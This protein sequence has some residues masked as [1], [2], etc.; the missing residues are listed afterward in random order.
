MILLYKYDLLKPEEVKAIPK[1]TRQDWDK[2]NLEKCYGQDICALY[3]S[4]LHDLSGAFKYSYIR[5]I[6]STSV[7]IQKTLTSLLGKSK[8]FKKVKRD[9]SAE[10]INLIHSLI[11][12]GISIK[13]ACKFLDV[14]KSWYHYHRNK[15]ECPK[16]LFK[17]CF[18]KHPNQLT[19]KEQNKIKSWIFLDKNQ[20]K[21][22]T[23]IFPYSNSMIEGTFHLFKHDFLRG[24]T[25]HSLDEVK[26]KTKLFEEHVA[27]RYFTEL[28]GL[29]PLQVIQGQKPN[30]YRYKKVIQK[31]QKERVIEN[32]HNNNCLNINCLQKES[33]S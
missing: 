32:Q 33:I 25:L 2:K 31:A 22:K 15:H 14:K 27:N 19:E 20:G 21:A 18:R 6:L 12:K 16:S 29:T 13:R 9:N 3:V 7:I 8:D 24:E 23:T 1:S 28:Y 4:N 11:Q 10:I 17:F 26:H 5:Y 30:K